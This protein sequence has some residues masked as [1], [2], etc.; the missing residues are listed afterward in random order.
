MLGILHE[1]G[2]LV[3]LGGGTVGVLL[4]EGRDDTSAML[5]GMGTWAGRSSL[6]CRGAF[7][8]VDAEDAGLPGFW[9]L[10]SSDIADPVAPGKATPNSVEPIRALM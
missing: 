9:P 7:L 5:A 1:G 2:D 4:G 10:W 8:L 3:P 6:Q